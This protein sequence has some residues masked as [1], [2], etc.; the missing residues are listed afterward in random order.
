M[1][2]L[3]LTESKLKNLVCE[4]VIRILNEN[5]S[6]LTEDKRTK[7]A[8]ARSLNV[9]RNHFGNASWLD[10]V[11]EHEDNPDRMTNIDY[12]FYHFEEEFY[13]D[14]RLRNGATMR[15]EP[16]FCR[17]AFEAGFQQS[18]PD[19]PK[20]QRLMA[21]LNLMYDLSSAGKIDLQTINIDT[22]T[23]E[24]LN[25]EFGKIIDQK[26]K[27]AADERNNTEYQENNDYKVIGPV[28]FET[29]NKYGSM[30]CPGGEICYTQNRDTWNGA[31]TRNDSNSVYIILKN[32]WENIPA[33]HDDRTESAYD[34]YGLSMIFVI[35]DDEGKLIYC[36]TRWNHHAK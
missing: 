16:L 1:R 33:K 12:M 15:L 23:F 4:S 19:V 21:I 3:T 24:D 2:I 5:M 6:L 32:G 34:T 17:L 13:H 9:I 26:A 30:S 22:T 35:V 25:N 18:N 8:H 27:E 14:P 11:F 7:Q 36:N 20:L 31:Y 29:A 28:D 10:T